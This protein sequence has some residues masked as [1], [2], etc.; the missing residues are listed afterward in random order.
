MLGRFGGWA[1]LTA[2]AIGGCQRPKAPADAGRESHGK[3]R[4]AHA[5][6]VETRTT[7]ARARSGVSAED[8]QPVPWIPTDPSVH[9][10]LERFR[11]GSERDRLAIAGLLMRMGSEEAMTGLVILLRELPPGDVKSVICQKLEK[12]EVGGKREFLLGLLLVDAD[13]EIARA[14]TSALGSQADEG[15]VG[16][17]VELN[18][19]VSD[20]TVRERLFDVLSQAS[21][22]AA[23]AAV[24]AI[25]ADS[26]RRPDDPLV[27]AASRALA[28]N[29]SP[30]ALDVLLRKLAGVRRESDAR[31]LTEVVGNIA[32]PRAHQALLYAAE[33][34]RVAP[35]TISRVAAIRALKN[36]PGE[37]T[38]E[39][40][41][42]LASDPDPQIQVA[43]REVAAACA[44]VLSGSNAPR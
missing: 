10:A 42:R 30:Q 7:G 43:A 11:N 31:G 34:N 13:Q 2:L 41:S 9:L 28:E 39:V 17:L 44:S 21:S 14:L 24:G 23:A 16:R 8:D 5:M 38:L 18:K 27:L 40:M 33:G 25:V 37:D 32:R 26:E 20:E 22:D 36:F 15:F 4:P 29:A 1:I 12:F 6:R 19:G 35:T 3:A